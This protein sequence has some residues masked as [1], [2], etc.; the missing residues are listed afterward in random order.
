MIRTIKAFGAGILL[1]ILI[2]PRSGAASRRLLVDRLAEFF[3]GGQRRFEELENDLAERR[4]GTGLRE[5]DWPEVDE[6]MPEIETILGEP[7]LG[8]GA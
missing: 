4:A 5:S 3:D 7:E 1:G 8:A 6:S 2:A